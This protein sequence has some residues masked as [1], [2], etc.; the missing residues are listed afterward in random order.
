MLFNMAL[1]GSVGV[2]GDVTNGFIE[3]PVVSEIAGR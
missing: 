2:N 3:D 1:N